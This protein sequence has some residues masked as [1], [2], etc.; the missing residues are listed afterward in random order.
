LV[1]YRANL[2]IRH[3]AKT[4]LKVFDRQV[5]LSSKIRI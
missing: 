4:T 2:A 1:R 3:Q 5:G